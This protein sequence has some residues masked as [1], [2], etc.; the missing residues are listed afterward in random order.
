M[1][2][3]TLNPSYINDLP[4][5]KSVFVSTS[6][7]P[8]KA[9]TSSE[10]IILTFESW[11]GLWTIPL[12]NILLIN[13]PTIIHSISSRVIDVISATILYLFSK[14]ICT[15]NKDVST[16]FEIFSNLIVKSLT[17]ITFPNI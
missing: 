6:C 2:A 8:T 9:I 7:L 13:S 3:E 10:F 14:T 4:I 5:Y 16:L 15:P 17:D 1:F 11:L 12:L